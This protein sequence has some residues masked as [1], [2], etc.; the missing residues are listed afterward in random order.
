MPRNVSQTV[1][2]NLAN[3]N[4]ANGPL[5]NHLLQTMISV[6]QL[7][8]LKML[9]SSMFASKL[10]P[11]LLALLQLANGTKLLQ[12][13]LLLMEDACHKLKSLMLP[14]L[15]IASFQLLN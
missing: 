9:L 12:Q 14:K 8:L 6:H 10:K 3:K 13:L 5:E 7:L 1:T 11:K 4:N 2:N 15:Q